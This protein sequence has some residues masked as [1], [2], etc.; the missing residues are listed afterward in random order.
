M[1]LTWIFAF[2]AILP[3]DD[4]TRTAFSLLFCILN[5]LQ[6]FFIFVAY[7]ILS[8]IKYVA[9]VI[10]QKKN[11]KIKAN[12]E[13]AIAEDDEDENVGIKKRKIYENET[14]TST[15]SSEEK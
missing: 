1:G 8:K 2:L 15:E 12:I 11:S 7:I 14:V 5:A 13:K 9:N 10:T 6:G 3:A 4:Y